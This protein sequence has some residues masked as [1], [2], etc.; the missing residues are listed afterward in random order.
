LF[1]K[2]E[3]TIF[4]ENTYAAMKSQLK[5]RGRSAILQDSSDIYDIN[6]WDNTQYFLVVYCGSEA[7]PLNVTFDTG[8][9]WLIV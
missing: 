9:D 5:N 7:S 1:G 8:S 4:F 3:E 2:S 6:D